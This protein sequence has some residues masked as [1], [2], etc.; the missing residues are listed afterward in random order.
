ML[1]NESASVSA[2]LHHLLQA[3][4][5]PHTVFTSHACQQSNGHVK[6]TFSGVLTVNMSCHSMTVA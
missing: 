2:I 4:R 6:R 3:A 5:M 1:A